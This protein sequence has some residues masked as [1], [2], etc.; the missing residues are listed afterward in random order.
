VVG[1]TIGRLTV[2]EVLAES[3]VRCRCMCGNE[4]TVR[5]GNLVSGRTASCGCWRRDRCRTLGKAQGPKR[6]GKGR[7]SLVTAGER[8]GRLVVQA[9]APNG[10]RTIDSHLQWLCRCDCGTLVVVRAGKLVAGYAQSEPRIEGEKPRRGRR[11]CGCGLLW[12]VERNA[13]FWQE[14]LEREREKAA[15]R[16]DISKALALQYG[17]SE[18]GNGPR[19]QRPKGSEE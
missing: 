10:E 1:Q 6:A 8:F 2:L 16:F 15:A 12:H 3:M 14:R 7:V 9:L 4:V 17:V 18:F 13:R 11:T 5:K 19:V